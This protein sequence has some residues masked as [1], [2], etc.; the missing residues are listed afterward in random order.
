M[1]IR[2]RTSRHEPRSPEPETERGR[3]TGG[4]RDVEPEDLAPDENGEAD[5]GRSTESGMHLKSFFAATVEAALAAG[6]RELGPEA[7]IV[8]SRRSPSEWRHLGEYEVVLA[9]TTPPAARASRPAAADAVPAP[10]D[11]LAREL[12]ELRRQLDGM[13]RSLSRSAVSAPRWLAPSSQ[14]AEIFS[15]LVAAEVELELA[16]QVAEAVAARLGPLP[17]DPEMARRAARVELESRFS[18][19]ASLGRPGADCRVVALA[20]PP[21]AGKTTTL[22]KLAAHWGL[23]A[24]RPVMLVSADYHRIGA[25]DQLRTF[26]AIL[27]MAYESVESP[28]ALAQ[29]LQQHAGKELI[30]IDTP[31]LAAAEMDQGHDLARFLAARPECDTH[32]VLSAS[33]KSADI[34]RAVDRFA[35][36]QPAKLLFTR[37]DETDSWGPILSEAART[38]K[39]ISFLAAGQQIPEHLEPATQSRLTEQLLPAAEA[40]AA[41]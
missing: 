40:R 36:F 5:G 12:A 7:M 31:G 30:L 2:L 22:V 9:V 27:G 11:P 41:A 8:Q 21:G 38:H 26:A 6:S 34:T 13:R 19:D 28:A 15:V 17:V 16:Q 23:K 24:R 3:N 25:A 35:I 1:R 4:R 14:A 20:G 10:G 32:L 39:P 33:M 18:V 29:V 37:L